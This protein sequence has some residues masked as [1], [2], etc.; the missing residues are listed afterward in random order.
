MWRPEQFK[1]H[2][3][4]CHYR[5]RRQLKAMIHELKYKLST[6]IFYNRYLNLQYTVMCAI[7]LTLAQCCFSSFMFMFLLSVYTYY[8]SLINL[9]VIKPKIQPI[10]T[11]VSRT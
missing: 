2:E 6:I 11:T 8:S 5:E 4:C 1:A 9:A 7:F 3:H 10:I